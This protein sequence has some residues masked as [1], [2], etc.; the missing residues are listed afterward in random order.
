MHGA[1]NVGVAS[2]V[3]RSGVDPKGYTK[4]K[5]I[6]QDDGM[7]RDIKHKKILNVIH[8][9]NHLTL[10]IYLNRQK[11]YQ[12]IVN[13]LI[14]IFNLLMI[15]ILKNAVYRLE[16]INHINHV[17][18]KMSRHLNEIHKQNMFMID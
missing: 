14:K 11:N 8:K 5:Q 16:K 4:S 3:S 18:M 2:Y 15:K 7:H 13:R 12:D 1:P 6:A 9:Q 17:H 10:L